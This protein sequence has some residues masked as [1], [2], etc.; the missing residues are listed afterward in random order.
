[1]FI[2]EEQ[3]LQLEEVQEQ[4]EEGEG[5]RAENLGFM[6]NIGGGVGTGG[7]LVLTQQSLEK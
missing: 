2:Q 7:L 6:K 1:M 4:E 5:G 3:E